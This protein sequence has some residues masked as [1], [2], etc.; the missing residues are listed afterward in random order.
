MTSPEGW[1]SLPDHL[2]AYPKW[3]DEHTGQLL[4]F[5]SFRGHL[6]ESGHLYQ[7]IYQTGAPITRKHLLETIYC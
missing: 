3:S 7:I 1:E 5:T 6:L 2:L 4:D